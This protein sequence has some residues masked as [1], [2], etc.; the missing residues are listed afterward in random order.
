MGVKENL[1]LM[2]EIKLKKT[3]KNR[4]LLKNGRSICSTEIL[5]CPLPKNLRSGDTIFKQSER[6]SKFVAFINEFHSQQNYVDWP[7]VGIRLKQLGLVH[8]ICGKFTKPIK[9]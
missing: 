3:N 9:L 8:S 7:V 1:N 5:T 4:L 6:S 2:K